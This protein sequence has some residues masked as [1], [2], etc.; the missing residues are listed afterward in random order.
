M[1]HTSSTLGI[2]VISSGVTPITPMVST[3]RKRAPCCAT[4][5]ARSSGVGA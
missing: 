3:A 2:A 5:A 4:A 1:Q